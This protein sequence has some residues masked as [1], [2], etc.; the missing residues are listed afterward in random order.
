MLSDLGES[1]NETTTDS[2]YSL[3]DT[4]ESSNSE[5]N[6]SDNEWEKEFFM[7]RR[8]FCIFYFH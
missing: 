4:E 2:N 5:W 3:H 7:R 6:S 1:D 8:M